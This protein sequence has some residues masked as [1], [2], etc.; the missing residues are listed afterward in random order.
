MGRQ[1]SNHPPRPS[2]PVVCVKRTV[3]GVLFKK[4]PSA[5]AQMLSMAS[6]P[7]DT[8]G[9][10]YSHNQWMGVH[11]P[12]SSQPSTTQMPDYHHG[13][14]YAPPAMP[15]E[16]SYSMPRPAPH[17]AGGSHPL[18]PPPLIMPHTALWPSMLTGNQSSYPPP[19]MP[20]APIQTPVSATNSHTPVDITPTSAKSTTS[21]RKL[22]DEE[23]RQMCVE[24]EQNPGMKQTQIGGM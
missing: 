2:H 19:L 14:D 21:R 7:H 17:F 12:N 22:T 4:T 24:A 13:Y 5:L 1:G 8:N 3:V 18:P 6:N 20:A 23:R 11:Y 15:M 9:A 16:P 10:G